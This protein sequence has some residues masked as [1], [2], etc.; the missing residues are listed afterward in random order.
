MRL[1]NACRSR[2][3]GLTFLPDRNACF[4]RL[5]VGTSLLVAVLF[6]GEYTGHAGQ[7]EYKY[8]VKGRVVDSQGQP[9]QGVSVYLDPPAWAH[10][11]FGFTTGP[12]GRFQLAEEFT[13]RGRWSTTRSVSSQCASSNPFFKE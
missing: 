12:D 6:C 11:I 10:Q 2:F 13:N 1:D 5:L 3:S 4:Y 8:R 9:V 7:K